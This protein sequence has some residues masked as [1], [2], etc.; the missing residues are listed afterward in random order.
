MDFDGNATFGD[1]GDGTAAIDSYLQFQQDMYTLGQDASSGVIV[2]ASSPNPGFENGTVA[3]I[4]DGLWTLGQYETDSRRQ[5]GRQY[6]AN[7]R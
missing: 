1:D 6:H 5:T 4:Y 3:M 2:D 7:A